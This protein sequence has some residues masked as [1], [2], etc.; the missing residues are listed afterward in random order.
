MQTPGM[1]ADAIQLVFWRAVPARV[2]RFRRCVLFHIEHFWHRYRCR[3]FPWWKTT[4]LKSLEVNHQN[5]GKSGDGHLF[6]QLGSLL[7]PS[8]SIAAV[9]HR[10]RLDEIREDILNGHW[11]PPLYAQREI[12]EAV[13][14]EALVSALEALDAAAEL[15][16]EEVGDH[17]IVALTEVLVPDLWLVVEWFFVAI[18]GF[19]FR[20]LGDS[21]EFV[22]HSIKQKTEKFLGVLLAIASEL[23]G[24]AA[25]AIFK[26]WGCDVGVLCFTCLYQELLVG[27][28]QPL[29]PHGPLIWKL[30]QKIS[31]E[32]CCGED[33]LE[34][35]IHEASITNILQSD[36]CI[37]KTRAID[38]GH[39]LE[40]HDSLNLRRA[41][42]IAERLVS[43][44]RLQPGIIALY[45]LLLLSVAIRTD[46][47]LLIWDD[48]SP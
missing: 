44:Y 45:L 16:F 38:F 28:A 5:L 12:E 22:V 7:A 27:L 3:Q 26:V 6:L 21:V 48:T 34:Y 23:A 36:R 31:C 13:E 35:T 1:M 4:H 25:D 15:T 11:R 9:F 39:F 10:F 17:W 24:Y 42:Q 32:W 8:T 41:E 20:L 19:V 33:A 40:R 46:R 43:P 14:G 2:L 18:D 29:W 37:S 47:L 30:G